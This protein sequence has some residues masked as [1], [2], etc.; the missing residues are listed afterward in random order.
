MLLPFPSSSC[1]TGLDRYLHVNQ[2]KSLNTAKHQRTWNWCTCQLKHLATLAT[3]MKGGAIGVCNKTQCFAN[4]LLPLRV[5]VLEDVIFG[6][7]DGKGDWEGVQKVLVLEGRRGS[8]LPLLASLHNPT[9]RVIFSKF[10][11]GSLFELA[12][13]AGIGGLQLCQDVGS[14]LT[15]LFK[16]RGSIGAVWLSQLSIK[17]G[18]GEVTD[19]FDKH[20]QCVPEFF[21]FGQVKH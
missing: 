20:L 17:G 9:Y 8:K 18:N 2:L 13:K 15:N 21:R 16:K 6:P 1:F 10:S 4:D 3:Y 12:R 14:T 7:N 19:L 11:P 5:K